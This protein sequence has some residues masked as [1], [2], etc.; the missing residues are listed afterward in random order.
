MYPRL[1]ITICTPSIL[2]VVAD[3]LGTQDVVLHSTFLNV[4][5]TTARLNLVLMLVAVA[6]IQFHSLIRIL[7]LHILILIWV[8]VD[9]GIY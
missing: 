5:D 8:R 4:V 2:R 6:V 9:F 7:S 3:R 1:Y